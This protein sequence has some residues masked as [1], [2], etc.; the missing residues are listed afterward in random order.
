MTGHV[1]QFIPY[2][3]ANSPKADYKV[4]TTKEKETKYTYKI[5]KQG[6]LY[7]KIGKG[8]VKLCLTN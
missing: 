7:H 6:N 1:I 5:Q 2:L 4:S 8:K 3:F